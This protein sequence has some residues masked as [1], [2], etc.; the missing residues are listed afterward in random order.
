MSSPTVPSLT[1]PLSL[2]PAPT[3]HFI[4]LL[5]LARTCFRFHFSLPPSLSSILLLSP[6]HGTDH[7]SSFF[8][9]SYEFGGV[10]CIG[11]L[12][13]VSSRTPFPYTRESP[14][15]S[16]LYDLIPSL[17]PACVPSQ[18]ELFTNFSLSN[19]FNLLPK[20]PAKTIR[21]PPITHTQI[22]RSKG[23]TIPYQTA[24]T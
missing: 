3:F 6:N 20:P 11:Q 22:I 9:I 8:S 1:W 7:P 18:H 24:F 23:D 21:H 13:V 4:V 12:F 15:R 16:Q 10:L 5:M 2:I 14:Q 17:S 19:L